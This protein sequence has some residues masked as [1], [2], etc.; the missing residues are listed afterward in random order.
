MNK[1]SKLNTKF[2]GFAPLLNFKHSYYNSVA[3]I[4]NVL[5]FNVHVA[6]IIVGI[7]PSQPQVPISNI[8]K[9]EVIAICQRIK[10]LRIQ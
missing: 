9:H 4:D 8:H 7:H 2:K 5:S 1:L 3:R 6:N 10:Y